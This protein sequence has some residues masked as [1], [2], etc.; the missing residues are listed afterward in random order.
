MRKLILVSIILLVQG[1]ATAYGPS[2]M[3]ERASY[4]YQK[5][6]KCG[7]DWLP[8]DMEKERFQHWKSTGNLGMCGPDRL[9][10]Q[11]MIDLV[12]MAHKTKGTSLFCVSYSKMAEAIMRHRQNHSNLL[13]IVSAS[14]NKG[15]QKLV[16]EAWGE[17][18]MISDKWKNIKIREFADLNLRACL[19][20]TAND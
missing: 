20:E 2:T 3:S 12:E 13:P 8:G 5:G 11:R 7:N 9:K 19:M 17:E 1:C 15:Y 18:P 4:G 14:N 6:I 16:L 10:Q